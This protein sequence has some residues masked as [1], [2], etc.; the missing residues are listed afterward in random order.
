MLIFSKSDRGLKRDENQDSFYTGFLSD[1]SAFAVV[2]D[3]MGGVG[4]GSV[5]SSVAVEEIVKYINNSYSRK[6]NRNSVLSLMKNA[7]IS[8]N[9]KVY[10][11]SKETSE[12]SGM[13]T[14]AVIL[15]VRNSFALVCHVGDSRAYLINDKITQITRD[16]SVVQ[17]LLENG[18]LTPDEAKAHPR[19]NVITR[20]LGAEKEVVPDLTELP[21]E[22]GDTVLV[23]SDGL[24]NFV[25]EDDIADIFENNDISAVAG[26]LVDTANQNGGGDNITVVTVTL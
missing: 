17:D 12:L 9:M 7:L 8:A 1:N 20:A 25:D 24:T 15:I 16:H 11:M 26:K 21:I 14:T 18:K 5:A 13:G 10:E 19:K 6:M 22:V 23:C 2:C 4:G 3:G